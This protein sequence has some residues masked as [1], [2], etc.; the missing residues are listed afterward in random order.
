MEKIV[1]SDAST[2]ILLEKIALLTPLTGRYS[3]LIPRTVETEAV[4]EGIAAQY[5]DAFRIQEK[6]QKKILVVKDA[7]D[8]EKITKLMNESNLGKGEAE[9]ICLGLEYEAATLA[10]DDHKAMLVCKIYTLPF[11][12][13]LTFVILAF[14]KKI[15]EKKEAREMIKMLDIFGRYKDELIYEALKIVG[16]TNDKT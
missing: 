3:F 1:I 4:K 6:I 5:P 7:K 2:L 9:A 8:T 16:E 13:A 14:Q 12:T 15:I 11:I 10:L